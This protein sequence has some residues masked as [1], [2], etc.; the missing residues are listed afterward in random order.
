MSNEELCDEDHKEYQAWIREVEAAVPP[1]LPEPV[2]KGGPERMR[3][4]QC[5]INDIKTI[6]STSKD[7]VLETI[8]D[9]FKVGT[10]QHNRL[11]YYVFQPYKTTYE[12]NIEYFKSKKF[13]EDVSKY[14]W[15][16]NRTEEKI[17]WFMITREVQA[18]Q[19][20]VNLLVYAYDHIDFKTTVGK[21][22]Y[23]AAWRQEYFNPDKEQIRRF[24]KYIFKE[25][26][27]R[28]LVRYLDFEMKLI[29]DESNT[30]EEILEP[31]SEELIVEE[32]P[33]TIRI[34]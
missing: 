18:T 24:Q 11:Y 13:V 7:Q 1:P 30:Y 17:F 15:R 5:Y 10:G 19:I 9:V 25:A 31:E 16:K 32:K 8:G 28:S 14:L 27:E 21:Q 26:S 29:D 20:H 34:V 22:G 33:L 2:A 23:F 12:S 4:A 3:E 6:D